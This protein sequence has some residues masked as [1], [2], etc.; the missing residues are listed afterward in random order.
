MG[1][2]LLHR[3]LAAGR[4]TARALRRRLRVATRPA[5]APLFTGTLADLARTKPELLA[6][7]VLLRQQLLI[8]RRP[9]KR[10]RCTRADRALWCCWP[11]ACARGGTRCSS[12][13]R[14]PCFAGIADSTDGTGGG[15]LA[16]PPRRTARPSRP[17]RSR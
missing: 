3:L 2:H 7:N 16:R 14:T 9:A 10:P 15:N 17:R 1:T 6:E 11:A 5:A 8:L 13:S 12:S 4:A